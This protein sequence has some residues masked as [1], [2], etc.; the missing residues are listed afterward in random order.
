MASTS[1][2]SLANVCM[3]CRSKPSVLYAPTGGRSTPLRVCSSRCLILHDSS[4]SSSSPNGA[5]DH[6]FKC[7]SPECSKMGDLDFEFSVG[8]R[9]RLAPRSH[10][11]AGP[12][13]YDPS[14]PY[15]D[16]NNNVKKLYCSAK[17]RSAELGRLG[18]QSQSQAPGFVSAFNKRT[19]YGL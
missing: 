5:T 14:D 11:D 4:Y 10:L 12:G 13:K 2:S 8:T 17:C 18:T 19:K 7:S 15:N 6:D 3:V 9:P 16:S 1:P